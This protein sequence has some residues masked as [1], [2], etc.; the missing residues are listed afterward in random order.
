MKGTASKK[1]ELSKRGKQP[2]TYRRVVTENV[3]GKSTVQSA[4][5]REG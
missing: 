1:T 4:L 5:S 3:N 2:H